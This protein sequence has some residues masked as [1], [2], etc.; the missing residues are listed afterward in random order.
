VNTVS[1]SAPPSSELPRR[2]QRDARDREEKRVLGDRLDRAVPSLRMG[3]QPIVRVSTKEIIAYEALVRPQDPELGTPALLLD[4][5]EKTDR[6]AEVGRAIRASV[7]R[8]LWTSGRRVHVFVNLHARD[9]FD[10]SLFEESAP[11]SAFAGQVT[12]EITERASLR[13]VPD[14]RARI[15]LLQSLG[16][17]IAL[18][19]LG[20][21]YAGLSLLAQLH[22]DVVK[23]DMSFTRGIETDSIKQKL[24]RSMRQLCE[25]LGTTFVVEGVETRAELAQLT[26]LGCDVFQGEL[27]GM[28]GEPFLEVDWK[29]TA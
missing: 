15:D 7:S 19:D 16:F 4:A 2:E 20:A 28:A 26:G 17:R 10:D 23:L 14:L 8:T 18:D 5:A 22:P 13:D 9:L 1:F 11:L 3:Y 25:E 6:L 12:L 24:V 21:G 27:F 29:K